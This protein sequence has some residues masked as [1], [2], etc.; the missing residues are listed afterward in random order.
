[1]PNRYLNTYDYTT[2]IQNS[3][4]NQV[5]QIPGVGGSPNNN[6]PYNNPKLVKAELTAMEEVKSYLTQR[7]DLTAEFTGTNPWNYYTTYSSGD[8]VILDYGTFS[9]T[10]DYSA[11]GSCVVYN[12]EA[13]MSLGNGATTS[14]PDINPSSWV[15]LGSQ[16]TIFYGNYNAPDFNTENFYNVNDVVYW[17]GDT[18]IATSPTRIL[19]DI[20]ALQYVRL[21]YLPPANIFPTDVNNNKNAQYWANQGTYS[22]PFGTLPMNT[23][24][25]TQGDNRC[26]Q[27][28]MFVMDITIYHL[29]KGLAP[30]N[31]PELRV[32][33]YNDAIKYLKMASVGDITL[34]L[35]EKKPTQ[36]LKIRFVGDVRRDNTW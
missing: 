18:W 4:L 1:M 30:M 19:T 10:A 20:E 15:D 34:N 9:S 36:G 7:W 6:S 25:W 31:I 29:S 2:I 33:A 22:I 28:V 23:A 17:A 3:Q 13:Y 24:Y 26:Q 32:K 11:T 35:P 14:T 21:E 16:Y 12:G 8:R 5:L 27:I